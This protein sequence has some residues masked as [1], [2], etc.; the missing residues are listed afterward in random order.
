MADEKRNAD[1]YQLKVNTFVTCGRDYTCVGTVNDISSGGF[2]FEHICRE[3]DLKAPVCSADIFLFGNEYYISDVSCR[4]VYDR[5]V[6][7]FNVFDTPFTSM[8]CGVEFLD[9]TLDQ[10]SK[11][12]YFITTYTAEK[13]PPVQQ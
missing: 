8:R 1:R 10:R 7:T 13:I 6:K 12:D 11:I 4:I 2:S 9:L 3:S 5:P